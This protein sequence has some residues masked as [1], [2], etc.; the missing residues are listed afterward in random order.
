MRGPIYQCF[1]QSEY[2]ARLDA[3]RERMVDRG[4]D[5]LVTTTP[6]NVFYLSGYQTPGY[7]FF[8]GLIVFQDREP[9]LIPPPHEESLVPAYSWVDEYRIN[10]DTSSSIETTSTV[11]KELGYGKG[12]V[13][14]ELGAWFLTANDV[15]EFAGY[16]PDAKLVDSDGLVEAGRLIKSDAELAHMRSAAKVAATAMQAGI[17]A[18]EIGVRERDIA[19]AV[20]QA[21]IS[22]GGE[23]SGLPAF[24]TSGERSMMV[25]ASWSDRVVADGEVVFLEVP[26]SVNRYHVAHS[27]AA[28]AGDPSD[29]LLKGVEVNSGALQLAKDL[30]KPGVDIA[31]VFGEVKRS[32]DE[33][34]VPYKQGRRIAYGIGTAFPPDWGEGH[35]ISINADEHREFR[36]G[37]VFH[38]ITTMRLLGIGAIGCS[39]TV[40][41]TRSGSETLTGGVPIDLYRR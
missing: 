1:E 13:A 34:D 31:E 19:A 30:I 27:R 18:I 38:I 24:V 41:V 32:I 22:A 10:A 35:I 20:Y 28:I 21:Q 39:D 12:V 6:E 4:V 17:D 3:L 15:D 11:I 8:L 26:G 5:V 7:Y 40:A 29:L 23:Y 14:L 33:S 16:L 36:S 25:H 2:Q 37:M 9:V